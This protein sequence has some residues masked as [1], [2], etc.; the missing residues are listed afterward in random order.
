MT[1]VRR[2]TFSHDSDS[3]MKPHPTIRVTFN[4][5][6]APSSLMVESK[7]EHVAAPQRKPL[8]RLFGSLADL[9]AALDDPECRDCDTC[10]R[11]YDAEHN[12]HH[13]PS[14]PE[15]E[16]MCETCHNDE[17]LAEMTEKLS[18]DEE[19]SP[20]T[21]ENIECPN[22]WCE[23]TQSELDSDDGC[24]ECGL[25]TNTDERGLGIGCD[26][27]ERCY[28]DECDWWNG[29]HV[30]AEYDIPHDWLSVCPECQNDTDLLERLDAD[31]EEY[32]AEYFRERHTKKFNP[33]LD[34]VLES[35]GWILPSACGF[36]KRKIAKIQ[37]ES[38]KVKQ[39][40][41]KWQKLYGEPQ[42]SDD[43]DLFML[44]Y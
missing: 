29:N 30:L 13:T 22:C 19:K 7:V 31:A 17:M 5:N 14:N 9:C 33:V 1:T 6:L 10:D 32:A 3:L 23:T 24:S 21:E 12:W 8:R 36:P 41:A 34:Q 42:S 40:N 26:F 38:E 35:Q 39:L 11:T 15:K 16:W 18:L 2:V 37:R 44:T 27:C 4:I 28:S 25:G 43:A 20:D